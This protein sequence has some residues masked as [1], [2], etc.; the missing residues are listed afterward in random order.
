MLGL[1]RTYESTGNDEESSVWYTKALK[2]LKNAAA[3]DSAKAMYLLG[4]MYRYGWGVAEDSEKAEA[5]FRK[6]AERGYLD[7]NW[8]EE[9]EEGKF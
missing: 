5:W 3:E 1:A 7:E 6:A 9:L 8:F 2:Q 4:Q